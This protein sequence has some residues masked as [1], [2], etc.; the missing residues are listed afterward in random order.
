MGLLPNSK[1][2]P[3]NYLFHVHHC[4][5]SVLSHCVPQDGVTALMCAS[6]NGHT[7]IVQL[8]L[9]EGA[10]VDLEIKV[11]HNIILTVMSLCSADTIFLV[12]VGENF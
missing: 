1:C 3:F 9:S 12:L 6:G 7:D 11:R 5:S 4:D 8:L 2:T 10:K